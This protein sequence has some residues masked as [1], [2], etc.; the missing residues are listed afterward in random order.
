MIADTVTHGQL[1]ADLPPAL[2]T[3]LVTVLAAGGAAGGLVRIERIVSRGQVTPP[4][5]WYEQTEDEFVL[6]ASGAARLGFTDGSVLALGPGDWVDLPAGVWH[7]VEWTA[8]DSETIWL[9]VF[10]SRAEAPAA[11]AAPEA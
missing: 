3:E 8:P 9:A 1:Q 2:P 10:R 11:P 6:L 4:G 5:T 7:R